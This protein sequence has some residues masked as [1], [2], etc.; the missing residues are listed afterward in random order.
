MYEKQVSFSTAF[1]FDV[2]KSVFRA[3]RHKNIRMNDYF[4]N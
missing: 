4:Y 3:I 1:Q 2:W